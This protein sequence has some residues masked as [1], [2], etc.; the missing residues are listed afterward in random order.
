[1]LVDEQA[2]ATKEAMESAVESCTTA[3]RSL[4]ESHQALALSEILANVLPGILAFMADDGEWSNAAGL[5]RAAKDMEASLGEVFP[6][7]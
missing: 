6:R 1:M 5:C 2:T 3:L 7:L 4:P